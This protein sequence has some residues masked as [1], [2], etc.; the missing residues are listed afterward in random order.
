MGIGQVDNDAL[1]GLDQAVAGKVQ[2]QQMAQLL[3]SD[4]DSGAGRKADDDRMGDKVD[5]HAQPGH[6]HGQLDEAHHQGHEPRQEHVLGRARGGQGK[7]G[8]QDQQRDGVGRP[9][10]QLVGGAPQG[11]DDGGHDGG[12][13]AHLRGQLGDEGIGHGLGQQDDGHGQAGDQVGP[14]VSALVGLKEAH[15]LQKKVWHG[16]QAL[17]HLDSLAFGA[18]HDP[19]IPGSAGGMPA[20]KL[21]SPRQARARPLPCASLAWMSGIRFC[22]AAISLSIRLRRLGTLYH[23]PDWRTR[24][25]N[26][27]RAGVEQP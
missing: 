10:V 4:Q 23:G 9:G 22:W 18:A 6:A 16:P 5:Q 3:D 7:E 20:P 27:A 1:D 17:Q 26:C 12:I 19:Q 13:D 11:A 15:R 24:G 8:G 25:E 2:A 14:Q 21:P